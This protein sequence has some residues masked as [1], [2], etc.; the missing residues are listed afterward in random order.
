MSSLDEAFVELIPEVIDEP[1]EGQ[2]PQSPAEVTLLGDI[3]DPPEDPS[4]IWFAPMRQ[5]DPAMRMAREPLSVRL[6]QAA[7][8]NPTLARVKGIR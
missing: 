1:E 6:A 3:P 8:R 5:P 2:A 4:V 7:L